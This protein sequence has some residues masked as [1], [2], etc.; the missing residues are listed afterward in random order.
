[1]QADSPTPARL[2][3]SAAQ[4]L[5]D[6]DDDLPPRPPQLY[7]GGG[8]AVASARLAEPGLRWAEDH[9]C[10]YG[11]AQVVCVLAWAT[12]VLVP[13]LF[14]WLV[15][16]GLLATVDG[17]AQLL[18]AAWALYAL[19]AACFVGAGCANPGVP[20]RPA[21]AP[22]ARVKAA[23]F[24]VPGERECPHPGDDYSISRD[25]K[26]YVG[27]FDH[28][29]EFVGNDVGRGN[30]PCFV[31]FLLTLGVLSGVLGALCVAVA[32]RQWAGSDALR[33]APL[34]PEWSVLG[35]VFFLVGGALY[36]CCGD[37]VCGSTGAM[38]LMMPGARWG[39]AAVLLVLA[40]VVG[41]PIVSDMWAHVEWERNP[42]AFYLVAPTLA[43]ALL[44]VSMA[45]H[46][47]W[48]LCT[49][50]SQ[51]LWLRAKGWGRGGKAAAAAELV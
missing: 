51:K 3:T 7:S 44:F 45:A 22:G 39:V 36:R 18:H 30:M 24:G 9:C 10:C 35:F 16:P 27:G 37:D 23:S 38:I 21:P 5:D 43:F 42:A 19:T 46:W 2:S 40:V 4:K 8:T 48:L 41:L 31:G 26:R 14:F 32:A 20:R 50:L 13:A 29:C 11:R 28:H 1:M 34:G 15:G 49:G 33:L 25:T 17:G 12:F 47:L 6:E